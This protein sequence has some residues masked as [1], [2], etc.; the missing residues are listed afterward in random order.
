M[1]SEEVSFT[2]DGQVPVSEGSLWPCGLKMAP[3]SSPVRAARY[4]VQ[5][6]L[7]VREF[8]KKLSFAAEK[9]PWTTMVSP[10][11]ELEFSVK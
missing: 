11:T 2:Y 7:T 9:V 6:P 4:P 1:F 5:L 10:L 3:L 8:P